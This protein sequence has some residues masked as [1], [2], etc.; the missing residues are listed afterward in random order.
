MIKKDKDISKWTC[1]KVEKVAKKNVGKNVG[2]IFVD[3]SIDWRNL[4][5]NLSS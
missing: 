2:K 5:K 3:I 4:I 1:G